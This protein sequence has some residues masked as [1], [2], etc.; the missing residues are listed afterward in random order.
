MGKGI[1]YLIVAI[2][3]ILSVIAV[4]YPLISIV[5]LLDLYYLFY[6]K[7]NKRHEKK[8]WKVCFMDYFIFNS[9]RCILSCDDL[10][11]T[12]NYVNNKKGNLVFLFSIS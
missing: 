10:A 5:L 3:V 9:G 4:G 7:E 2:A 6:W 11:F 1:K 12:C 8:Y